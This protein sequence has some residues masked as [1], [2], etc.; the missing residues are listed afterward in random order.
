MRNRSLPPVFCQPFLANRFLPTVFRCPPFARTGQPFYTETSHE[1]FSGRPPGAV[2][3]GGEVELKR[4]LTAV[5]IL[6]AG[7]PVGVSLTGCG[8]NVSHFCDVSETTRTNQIVSI[9]L[10]PRFSTLS[11]AY[12]QTRAMSQ[13]SALNCLGQGIGIRS[14]DWT[15]SN[16]SLLDVSP[17][18]TLCSGTWNRNTGGGIADFTI[19]SQPS[20]ATIENL[21]QQGGGTYSAFHVNI[22]ASAG[23]VASNPVTVYSHP[24]VTTAFGY[25]VPGAAGT[26]SA[27]TN[28]YGIQC[29]G[30]ATGTVPAPQCYSQQGQQA[31]TYCAVVCSQALAEN[32]NGTFSTQLIDVTGAAGDITFAPSNA[33][34][35]TISPSTMPPAGVATP[36]A[37]GA[38]LVTASVSGVTAAAGVWST[39]A[40]AAMMLA[41]PGPNSTSSTVN[42]SINQPQAL[43]LTATD[44]NNQ[45]VNLSG[46]IYTS[47]TPRSLGVTQAGITTPIFGGNGDIYAACL[48]PACNPSPISDIG[49]FATTSPAASGG[50]GVPLTSNPINVITPGT[51]TS[52]A[53][54]ANFDTV[55]YPDAN[56]FAVYN[57][58]TNSIST[59]STVYRPNSMVLSQDAT[60]LFL[61]SNLGLM[62]YP[63]SGSTVGSPAINGNIYGRVLAASPDNSTLIIAGYTGNNPAT[64]S[65]LIYVYATANGGYLQ[66]GGTAYS[67]QWSADGNTAY[68]AGGNQ[69]YVYSRF[70]GFSTYAAPAAES[71]A[72]DVAVLAP[73]VGAFFAG[74][75][76]EARSYC[77]DTAATPPVYNP[78]MTPT[79]QPSERL[80]ISSDGFHLFSAVS[81]TSGNFNDFC[82]GIPTMGGGSTVTGICKPS[83]VAPIAACS[84]AFAV[85]AADT[86]ATAAV[87][88]GFSVTGIP[89]ATSSATSMTGTLTSYTAFVT[90]SD[91]TNTLAFGESCPGNPPAAGALPYYA[92]T[93]GTVGAAGTL[94]L[95]DPGSPV[96]PIAPTAGVISPD[97]T[98]A[99]IATS[100]DNALHFVSIGMGGVPTE[101]VNANPPIAI[102]IPASPT[103]PAFIPVDKIVVKPFRSN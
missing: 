72:V 38:T 5:V 25:T 46:L 7:L 76:T 96:A 62:T 54:L 70:T 30:S 49:L 52:I 57:S 16:P 11:L 10:Q 71:N 43:T 19:C 9:L 69:E 51:E 14:F 17:T 64:G 1:K 65:P 63:L 36:I 90:Y 55:E 21:L 84:P 77:P 4:L 23:G 8:S 39:C 78:P 97:S 93:Q 2:R 67:A 81:A 95:T 79:G 53:Y 44:S 40:P 27:C 12:T 28:Q 18:G 101:N 31:V 94:T 32:S 80:G 102:G 66:F 88:A 20:T 89:V 48:Q 87:P 41:V 68:I 33:G 75:N 22:T 73:A 56:Y 85:T 35:V 50:N 61:G 60:R 83:P 92:V 74:N 34:V 13:P 15:S 99:F 47:T 29:D 82:I 59:V 45:P 3:A 91:C 100:G 26:Q 58:E 37:P 98:M 24:Q 6:L 86:P 103:S 42:V